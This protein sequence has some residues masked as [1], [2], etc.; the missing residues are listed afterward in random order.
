MF[1]LIGKALMSIDALTAQNEK[2]PLWPFLKLLLGFWTGSTRQ[3]AWLLSAGLFTS[4]IANLLVAIAI[5]HWNKYFF[6]ALQN[7]EPQRLRWSIAL[8][9]M[10]ALLS[11]VASLALFQ[12]RTR[13]QLRWRKWLTETLIR[14]WIEKRRFYQLSVLGLID[15][16]EA[17]IAEDG[18]QSVELLVDFVAGITNAFLGSASFIGILWFVGGSINLFGVAIPGY[19][20][21]AVVAYSALTSYGMFVL[22]RPLV[23]RVEKKASGEADLRYELTHTRENAENIALL[24]GDDD[25]RTR[26][27]ATFNELVKRWLDVISRQARMLFLANGNNVLAPIV[28]LLLGAPKYLSGDMSL[29]D[30][31]QAAAAFAQVQMALNWL[32]DNSLRL[33]D[34]F[35]SARRVAALDKSFDQLDAS[36]A[37]LG[38]NTINLGFSDDGALHLKG[39]SIAQLDGTLMLADADARI[40]RGEKVLVKGNALPGKST[41]IRAIAGLW[42]W[43]SGDI[44]RP[45]GTTFAFMP[46]RPY[47]PF[48]SLR[49][50][51]NYPQGGE[52]PD[53]DRIRTVF[54]E[55]GLDCLISQLDVEEDWS[56][57]LSNNEQ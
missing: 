29:G 36:V 10:L 1:G 51:I 17:R 48:G 9:I 27:N 31:M 39:L 23:E 16:P 6:D 28:P 11:A 41:L 43:G 25:E 12:V 52:T 18:R 13:L 19:M 20:V 33:A 44:L 49:A 7:K 32:A 26:L 40:A 45:R 3:V 14:K 53:E 50:A 22:G 57:L 30:L 47:I 4:L 56:G 21:I 54:I 34:W 37:S 24:G 46:Q 15:N 8:V 2:Q 42:P 35:A 38:D 55:C 5:N